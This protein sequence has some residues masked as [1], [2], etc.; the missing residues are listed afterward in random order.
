MLRLLKLTYVAYLYKKYFKKYWL[1]WQQNLH[2]TMDNDEVTALTLLDWSAAFG[3]IDHATLIYRLSDWYGISGQA[4]IWFC[5]LF[6][7][8]KYKSI[9][10]KITL[11]DKVT[12]AYGVQQ[13]S[14]LG[15]LFFTLYTTP[16]SAKI[17]SF[18]EKHHL[19]ADDTQMYM[20]WISFK[21]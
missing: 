15:P 21:R 14:A 16:I 19:D 7:N 13:G 17:F 12:L 5:F 9:K 8:H 18:D 11:W 1:H 4:Q 10:I 20:S 2:I 3:T 6:T